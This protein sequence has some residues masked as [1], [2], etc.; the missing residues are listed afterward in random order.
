MRKVFGAKCCRERL[1]C[2]PEG[3]RSH[4]ELGPHGRV[5]Q[6]REVRTHAF[7]LSACFHAAMTLTFPCLRERGL[8]LMTISTS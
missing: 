1:S 2:L 6:L 8:L 3:E 5:S 7:Q 4:A